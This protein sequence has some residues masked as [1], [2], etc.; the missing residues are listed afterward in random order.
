M[1]QGYYKILI[2]T[3]LVFHFTFLEISILRRAS[4]SKEI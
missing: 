2:G 3:Q 4:K 1:F